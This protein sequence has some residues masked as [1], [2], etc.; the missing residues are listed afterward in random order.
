MMRWFLHAKLHGAIVTE[1]E[2]HYKGSITIDE[3][4]LEKS[5]LM[6]GEKVLVVAKQSGARLETYVI[7]GKRDSGTICMNGP[8]AKLVTKGE[9]IVIMGFAMAEKT[10]PAKAVLVDK[11]NKF[12]KY[13]PGYGLDGEPWTDEQG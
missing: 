13:L 2:L 7:P 9:Q 10:L 11:E 6:A 12:V 1:A 5:G 8:A 4:L 3:A